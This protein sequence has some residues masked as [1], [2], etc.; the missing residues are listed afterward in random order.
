MKLRTRISSCTTARYTVFHS[1][2]LGVARRRGKREKCPR[3]CYWV[4]NSK[5]SPKD[6]HEI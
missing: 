4:L 3:L 2:A 5:T 6:K 1:Q